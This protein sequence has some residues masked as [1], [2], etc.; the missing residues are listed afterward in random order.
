MPPYCYKRA[1]L[2][3][4]IPV[5]KILL[6]KE[7]QGLVILSFPSDVHILKPM[8]PYV[9]VEK[10]GKST[11]IFIHSSAAPSWRGWAVVYVHVRVQGADSRWNLWHDLKIVCSML[12]NI[13]SFQRRQLTLQA[14]NWCSST[15]AGIARISCGNERTSNV[16]IGWDRYWYLTSTCFQSFINRATFAFVFAGVQRCCIVVFLRT[17]HIVKDILWPLSDEVSYE[18]YKNT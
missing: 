10:N 6:S 18:P 1:Y 9:K 12:R 16:R 13:T 5:Y 7:F 14:L 2:R 17:G 3:F 15:T 4:D 8:P 11:H